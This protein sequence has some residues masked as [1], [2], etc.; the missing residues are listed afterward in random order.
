MKVRIQLIRDNVDVVLDILGYAGS[1]F[2]WNMPAPM[3]WLVLEDG[4]K[5][6]GFTYEPSV[7]ELAEMTEQGRESLYTAMAKVVEE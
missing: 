4:T 6:D 7:C 1:S 2:E 3:G 5:M